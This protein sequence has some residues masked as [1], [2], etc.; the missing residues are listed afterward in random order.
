[1]PSAT[2]KLFRNGGSQAVRLPAEFRFD[3][4]DEVRIWRDPATGDV[5]LSGRKQTLEE[6]FELR[7]KLGPLDRDDIAALTY[8]DQGSHQDRD[9]FAGWSETETP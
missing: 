3:G 1:M 4:L 7:A 2:A 6:F 8:R 9:P 5:V